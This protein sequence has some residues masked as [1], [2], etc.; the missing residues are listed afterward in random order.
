MM[1]KMPSQRLRT[2]ST[3]TFGACA[4]GEKAMMGAPLYSILYRNAGF[5]PYSHNYLLMFIYSCLQERDRNIARQRAV[6][7]KIIIVVCVKICYSEARNRNGRRPLS[8]M[9]YFA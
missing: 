1:R 5:L 2:V 7:Q 3:G 4:V 9:E 8:A 6:R